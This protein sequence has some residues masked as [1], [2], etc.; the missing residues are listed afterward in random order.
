MIPGKGHPQISK[1]NTSAAL[2]WVKCKV[3][4]SY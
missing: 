4:H 3:K 1:P 2:E